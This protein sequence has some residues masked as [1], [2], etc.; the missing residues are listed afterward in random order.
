M[1]NTCADTQNL[2]TAGNQTFTQVGLSA[3]SLALF[4]ETRPTNKFFKKKQQKSKT[5]FLTQ[6]FANTCRI[7]NGREVNLKLCEFESNFSALALASAPFFLYFSKTHGSALCAILYKNSHFSA[8][9]RKN[10]LKNIT[11]QVLLL[12]LLNVLLKSSMIYSFAD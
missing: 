2:E 4:L 9:L 3:N 10:Y 1:I 12:I 7:C 6:I 11:T 8:I 5:M